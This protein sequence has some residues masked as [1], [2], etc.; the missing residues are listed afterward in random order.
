MLACRSERRD[1]PSAKK[2]KSVESRMIAQARAT[3]DPG[4]AF[5]ES[6]VS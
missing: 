2:V 3:S 5:Q 6:S 4:R 1:L